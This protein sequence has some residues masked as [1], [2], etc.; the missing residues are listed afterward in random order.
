QTWADGLEEGYRSECERLGREP[1]LCIVPP[2]GTATSA[3]VA[4]DVE[5]AW[6]R[7]GPYLLHDAR[8]YASWLGDTAAA[9]K[10]SALN[11]ESL[12]AEQGAYR[13]FTPEQAVEY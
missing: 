11:I 5:Q 13:V 4:E 12:R 6:P 9:S 10:S 8:M 1:G 3:F 2:P 7:L